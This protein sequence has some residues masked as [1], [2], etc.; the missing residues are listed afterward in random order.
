[1]FAETYGADRLLE[2]GFYNRVVPD[3]DLGAAAQ[4]FADKVLRQPPIPTTM[5]KLSVNAFVRA[6]DRAVFHLD[7][8]GVTLTGRTRDS[9]TAKEAFF[10]GEAVQWDNE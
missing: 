9:A 3:G 4:A 2:Y 10:S 1:M 5:T 8:P 7:A 6:L